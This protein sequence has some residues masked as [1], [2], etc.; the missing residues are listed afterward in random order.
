M[1]VR[2]WPDTSKI[3]KA[4]TKVEVLS[5]DVDRTVACGLGDGEEQWGRPLSQTGCS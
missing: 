3:L 1:V 5:V 2:H 4:H